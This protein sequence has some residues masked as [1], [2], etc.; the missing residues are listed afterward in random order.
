MHFSFYALR[1][2]VMFPSRYQIFRLSLIAFLCGVALFSSG[3]V[4]FFSAYVLILFCGVVALLGRNM[5]GMRYAC[6]VVGCFSL[7]M[8]VTARTGA[9]EVFIPD[10]TPFSFS[11]RISADPSFQ[12]AHQ[13]LML[14]AVEHDPAVRGALRVVVP[15]FPAYRIDEQV[16]GTCSS[17][18]KAQRNGAA[19]TCVFGAITARQESE[20]SLRGVLGRV[21]NFFGDA[22]GAGLPRPQ[23]DLLAGL[24]IGVHGSFSTDLADIFRRSGLSHIVAVSGSN[25]SLVIAGLWSIF[26]S[27][28]IGRRKSFWV[29]VCGIVL[30]VLL[31]GATS[32]TVRAGSMGL[33]I[34]YAQY[35]GRLSQST[36]VLLVT[37]TGMVALNPGILLNNIGFQLSCLATLGLIVLSPHLVARLVFVPAWGGIRDVVAQTLSA[38][39]FT[40]PLI[41]AVFQ[42]FSVVGFFANILV[43][44]VIPFIMAIGFGWSTVAA[45]SFA[46]GGIFS[47]SFQSFVSFL[48]LPVYGFLSYCIQTASF[49]ASLPYASIALDPGSWTPAFL[50]CS[51]AAVALLV[52]ALS[53]DYRH[54]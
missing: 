5:V 10:H 33:L 38:M 8:M 28:R 51:Y 21:R 14:D 11:G 3:V 42:T 6:I 18:K 4:H 46:L 16:S 25:I 39:L 31:T 26:A 24:L 20:L 49:F 7:G 19:P 13:V 37:A 9:I 52:W 53:I 32:A 54:E 12:N 40:A 45:A 30:F 36:P 23:S 41:I 43:V 2:F 34:L 44:P 15:L 29:M 22:I 47:F 50:L 17:F 1:F 27:M 48:A 35:I